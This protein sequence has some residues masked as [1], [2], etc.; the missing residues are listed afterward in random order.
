VPALRACHRAASQLLRR[1]PNYFQ[2]RA[3]HLPVLR[4]RAL[5]VRRRGQV[6]YVNPALDHGWRVLP[7]RPLRGDAVRPLTVTVAE[8]AE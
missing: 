2:P 7:Y 1:H 5:R 6:E 8:E 3:T 4:Y